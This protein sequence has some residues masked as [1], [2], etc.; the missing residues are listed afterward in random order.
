MI[1]YPYSIYKLQHL[2]L[3]RFGEDFCKRENLP[4]ET[5]GS[6][7]DYIASNI[8]DEQ[9]HMRSALSPFAEVDETDRD[10]STDVEDLA[11]GPDLREERGFTT[12]PGVP[13]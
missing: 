2:D 12:L 10:D 11:E 9:E 7:A 1:L 4:A 3:A 5:V 6:I 13:G 8:E